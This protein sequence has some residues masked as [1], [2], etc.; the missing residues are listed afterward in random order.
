MR[1]AE[2]YLLVYSVCTQ[3]PTMC[4]SESFAG[5]PWRQQ[6]N[7]L[8]GGLSANMADSRV[9]LQVELGRAYHLRHHHVR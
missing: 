6:S 9:R 2:P 5:M 3:E 4:F 8:R 7:F 1:L